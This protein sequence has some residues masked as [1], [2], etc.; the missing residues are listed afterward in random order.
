ML[1]YH[2]MKASR[3]LGAVLAS[4]ICLPLAGC[5]NASDPWGEGSQI[6]TVDDMYPIG[7]HKR[8]G[9][10]W[11]N[12]ANDESNH[13]SPN[14]GCAVHANIAAMVANKRVLK[15]PQPLGPSRAS[16][17]VSAITMYESNAGTASSSSTS[18]GTGSSTTTP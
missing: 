18:S 13:F 7:V 4:A 15:H 1:K 2:T 3:L 11:P 10:Y 12:L 5:L 9:K 14:H 6:Y 8:C 16:T 17:S